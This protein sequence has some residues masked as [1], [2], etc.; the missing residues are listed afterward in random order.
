MVEN[1]SLQWTLLAVSVAGLL[2]FAKMAVCQ[3]LQPHSLA[4][5]VLTLTSTGRA[6]ARIPR[7]M[8]V[9]A[10][11]HRRYGTVSACIGH[12]RLFLPTQDGTNVDID[13]S[14]SVDVLVPAPPTVDTRRARGHDG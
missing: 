1:R 8:V 6:V 11:I 12:S 14:A 5:D 7:A 3:R 4:D 10:R 9:G 2:L 13:L